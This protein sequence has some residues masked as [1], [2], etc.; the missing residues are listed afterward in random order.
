MSTGLPSEGRSARTCERT[1]LRLVPADGQRTWRVAQTSYGAVAP[2]P[3]AADYTGV[4]GWA[5]WDSAGGRTIYTAES[6]LFAYLEVLAY[7]TPSDGLDQLPL[8]AAFPQ[9]EDP[10]DHD[11]GSVLDRIRKEWDHKFAGFGPGKNPQRWREARSIYT[12]ELPT[13]GWFIDV[14]HNDTIAALNRTGGPL[15]GPFH[16]TARVTLA[17][18][19]DENREWSCRLATLLR[20]VVLD[21]GSYSHGIRF[22]SKHGA[23]GK[24][25]AIWLRRVDDGYDPAFEPVVV[26]GPNEIQH[27]CRNTPL[28][29]AAQTFG[30]TL[31]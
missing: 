27:P 9:S 31:Y 11:I 23:N 10:E 14:T 21:D 26:T 6:E 4:L 5:R 29:D 12:V 16:P 17:N 22:R 19:V 7:L 2:R 1:G 3:R 15:G 30:V 18:L 25:W 24:C 28:R 20:E 8:T 13:D